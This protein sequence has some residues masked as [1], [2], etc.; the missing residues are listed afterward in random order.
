MEFRRVEDLQSAMKLVRILVALLM[1]HSMTGCAEE[2]PRA[3]T[4]KERFFVPA[5]KRKTLAQRSRTGD[6]LAARQLFLHYRMVEWKP[7]EAQLWAEIGAK[8]GD[9]TCKKFLRE[10]A[11]ASTQKPAN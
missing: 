10:E 6:G 7:A 4:F 11:K 5:E 9:E 8:N 2:N 1:G 3:G